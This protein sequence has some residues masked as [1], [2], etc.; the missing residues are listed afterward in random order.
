MDFAERLNRIVVT[1]DKDRQG[2]HNCRV[3]RIELHPPDTAIC[4]ASCCGSTG[5]AAAR[6]DNIN[7]IFLAW[8]L[9][10]SEILDANELE[11]SIDIAPVFQHP[12]RTIQTGRGCGAIVTLPGTIVWRQREAYIR[13]LDFRAVSVL[14][15]GDVP[16]YFDEVTADHLG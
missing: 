8:A 5:S 7:N 10:V 4:G 3:I 16:G 9:I 15:C 1:F 11:D 14:P 2:G 12:L 6:I 13:S